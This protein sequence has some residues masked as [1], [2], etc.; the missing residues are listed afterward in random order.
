MCCIQIVYSLA[1]DNAYNLYTAW[2]GM[3][4][5][6][7]TIRIS[8]RANKIITKYLAYLNKKRGLKANAT[9]KSLIDQ[10]A[11]DLQTKMPTGK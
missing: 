11:E 5:D 7:T 6:D 9:K 2:Y 3:H 8:K 4:M 1:V 10:F